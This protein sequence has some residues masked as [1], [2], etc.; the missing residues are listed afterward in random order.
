MNIRKHSSQFSIYIFTTNVDLGASAKVHLSQAGYDAHFFQDNE[1][2]SQNLRQNPPHVLVFATSS[3]V[4][5]L[6]DFVNEAQKA[7]D[8][9]KFVAISSFDQ[10]DTLSQYHNYGMVDV[11]SEENAA[12][13]LRI[14]WAVDRA[15][16]KLY[17]TYQNEQLIDD[18]HSKNEELQKISS[19]ALNARQIQQQISSHSVSVHIADYRTAQSKEELIDKYFRHIP[20]VLCLFFKFLPSV[21]SFVATHGVGVPVTEIQGIGVQLETLDPKEL[22][23]QLAVGLLPPQFSDMLVEAFHLNPPQVL[24]LY[25]QNNLEGVFVYSGAIDAGEYTA[26]TEEFILLSL[27]YSNF[28]LENKVDAL[29][30]RDFVTELF[31]RQYY[32]K[33][34]TAEVE[35]ARR[36]RLPVSVLKIS[37][38]EYHQIESSLGE[39]VRDDLLKSVATVINKTGRLNDVTCRT[40]ANEISII[41]PHCSKKG[42]ALRAERLR[43]MVEGTSFLNNG[44][45]VSISL[46]I[47]EYP[48][49]CDNDKA[50]DETAVK[51][52]THI[53]DKGGNKVCLFKAHESYRPEFEVAVE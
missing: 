51:A 26:L 5:P 23:S 16:E 35:R 41:L 36:L 19:E 12:L 11:T 40:L 7:S 39:G 52:L 45:K 53:M 25:S 22:T 4:V 10:F 44:M 48:S 1:T 50:L 28:V 31:N 20:D 49:L 34:L 6:S 3:L 46:G 13:E 32:F 2:L 30:V 17:L 37:M 8:E 42:A 38:D 21:K 43:R 29:E 47:S 15:C 14:V 24:P 9:I 27:C 18:L 33:A